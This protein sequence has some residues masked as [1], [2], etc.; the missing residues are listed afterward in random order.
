M[1][2]D[3]SQLL[4]ELHDGLIA[5][6]A[7]DGMRLSHVDMTLPIELRPIFRDGGCVLLADFARS[8]EINDWTATPSRLHLGWGSADAAEADA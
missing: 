2:R 1:L 3:L 5:I 8:S 4:S 6:E 7:R